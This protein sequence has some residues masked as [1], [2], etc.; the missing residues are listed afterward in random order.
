MGSEI[1]VNLCYEFSAGSGNAREQ[2]PNGI[3]P[4]KIT[5]I[6]EKLKHENH[7]IIRRVRQTA[8]AFVQ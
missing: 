5:A 8:L 3:C 7:I 1:F 6:E 4:E 2:H